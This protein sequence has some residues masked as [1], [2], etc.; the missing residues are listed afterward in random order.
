[1][2]ALPR[3]IGYLTAQKMKMLSHNGKGNDVTRPD[4]IA[5]YGFDTKFAGHMARLGMQGVEL[6][7]TGRISLPMP[8]YAAKV[9]RDIRNGVYKMSETV[10][11]ADTY[12]AELRLLEDDPRLPAHPD[13]DAGDKWLVKAYQGQWLLNGLI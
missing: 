10:E 3:Y 8:E 5:R 4:L 7:M 2:E 9:V 6:M 13:R 11:M 1:M 12:L